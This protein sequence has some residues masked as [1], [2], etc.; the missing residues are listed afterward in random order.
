[1]K[2]PAIVVGLEVNGLSV[3]RSLGRQGVPVIALTSDLR[4]PTAQTRYCK[5]MF[6]EDERSNVVI[7][8]LI[9]L[10]KKLKQKVPLFLTMDKTVK[11]VSENREKLEPYYFN[12]L[13]TKSVIELLQNKTLFTDF[14]LKNGFLIPKTFILDSAAYLKKAIEQIRF[15]VIVKPCE[16]EAKFD[17]TF[18]GRAFISETSGQLVGEL[19]K[20]DWSQKL[21][22]Q[23]FI[24]GEDSDIYFCLG[25]FNS[26]S[27][28]LA[29][30]VGR[31]IRAWPL[32][33][34]N[35]ACA[36]PVD[37]N[38]ILDL[39]LQFFEIA[40][41]TG[42]GSLEFKK[43]KK[44]GQFYLIEP[45][46]GR[47]DYQGGIAPANGINIPYVAYCNMLSLTILE[48]KQSHK[49]VK[50]IDRVPDNRAKEQSV[51]EGK[52]TNAEYKKSLSGRKV[53]SVFAWDDP[54]PSLCILK[55]KIKNRIKKIILSFLD[56]FPCV[57]CLFWRLIPPDIRWPA[58]DITEKL[59]QNKALNN[60]YL[61]FF[62]RDPERSVPREDK[63]VVAPADGVIRSI[64][65]VGNKIIIDISMNFYDVHIQRVP[66]SGKVVSVLEV[67]HKLEKGSAEE[68]LY[69]EDPWSY[70]KDYL[71]PVQKV[72]MLNTEIGEV[73]IRQITSIWARRIETYVKPGENVKIGQRLGGIFLGST[74][75]LE[76]PSFVKLEVNAA[77]ANG[78]K[79]KRTDKPILAGETIIA[80]Y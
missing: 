80:R 9:G 12:Y 52:L 15:P 60:N 46:V 8:A 1:M 70:E 63:I 78:R 26:Q 6:C 39:T 55:S 27:K 68:K 7:P 77:L 51:K 75:V 24:E 31:K 49:K 41:F 71:F 29:T 74:V 50:W 17:S 40:R 45:T 18:R 65:T 19:E 20:Y 79:R 11:I 64:K 33:K 73:I 38:Q 56:V 69:F 43:D 37:E 44:T 21:I 42:L 22:L 57:Y 32:K 72:I 59:K 66:L 47:T 13:P 14:A 3:I 48:Y 67:G 76:L 10:G 28:P 16:K 25:Y 58:Q 23:E 36:E 2:S 4:Q 53:Y 34:G 62:L 61:S 30:F 35:T 54:L 5:K